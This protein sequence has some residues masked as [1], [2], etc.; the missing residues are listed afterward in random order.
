MGSSRKSSQSVIQQVTTTGPLFID[1]E[2][3]ATGDLPEIG[4]P[5]YARTIVNTPCIAWAYLD[6]PVNL[7]LPGDSTAWLNNHNGA[8]VAHNAEFERE[9]L[10]VAFLCDTPIDRWEDTAALARSVNLPGKL[11]EVGAFM[12]FPK[13]MEGQRIMMK[14]CR[15][16]RPSKDNPDLFWTPETKPNDFDAL[17]RYCER[18]VEVSREVY[19][20]FGPMDPVELRRYRITLTM[21]ARGV[22]VDL[23]AV[24]HGVRLAQ[25]ESDRLSARVEELTG[26]SASQVGKLSEFLSMDSIAKAPLRDAL[27]DPNLAPEAREVLALRQQFA[28]ASVA[29]LRAF[30]RHAVDGRLHDSLIYAG[31][32]RTCRWTGTGVQLQNVPRGAGEVSVEVIERLSRDGIL[33]RRIWDGE[34]TCYEGANEILKQTMRAL[35]VGPFLVGDYGQIEA[36]LLSFIAGDQKLLGAFERGED[37]YKLMAAGIYHKDVADVTKG[38]RFMGKQAVL[39]A[40]YGLGHR[41]FRNLL[42]LTYDVQIEEEEASRIID[43][44]R[45]ASPEVVQLWKKLDRAMGFSARIIGKRVVILPGLSMK[46]TDPRTMTIRLPSGRDLW[47]RNVEYRPREGWR[48]YGRDRVTKQMGRVPIHGGALTGHIVQSTARDIMASALERL[49]DAGF[50]TVLSV[51]DEAVVESAPERLKEF[52]QVMLALPPWAKGLP[53]KVDVFATERYRK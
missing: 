37:P 20:R 42:D 41:G 26:A 23:P 22:K 24:A 6:G 34:G 15:P 14:L 32:E 43:G 19:R 40:G 5:A 4:A 29:K 25:L 44:Y 39:G 38:E 8:F 28:K 21:N 13:D 50:R 31:A 36:R 1:I 33:P 16:R 9:V 47:Y 46:F 53:V 18:D 10:K 30:E 12:G 49:E 45:R 48:A 7:W 3:Q 35:L 52:E 2:T 51:H 11:E 17:Y 27:K